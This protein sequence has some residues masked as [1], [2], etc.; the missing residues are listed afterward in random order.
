MDAAPKKKHKKKCHHCRFRGRASTREQRL[1][2][3]CAAAT[4]AP[5]STFIRCTG[6]RGGA[7]YVCFTCL[8]AIAARFQDDVRKQASSMRPC[9]HPVLEALGGTVDFEALEVEATNHDS[10]RV[11]EAGGGVIVR[12]GGG[13]EWRDAECPLCFDVRFPSLPPVLPPVEQKATADVI[14]YLTLRGTIACPGCPARRRRSPCARTGARRRRRGR[15]R[16]R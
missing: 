2:S 3:P 6:C 14:M 13:F 15:G 9:S 8:A 5:R 1:R 10:S 16:P 7:A 4:G 11:T 12:R